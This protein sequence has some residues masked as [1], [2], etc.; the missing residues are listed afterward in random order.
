MVKVQSAK[1][2]SRRVPLCSLYREGTQSHRLE[3]Q[4]RWS[5]AATSSRT[6][7]TTWIRSTF[8]IWT[9]MEAR[10]T[11]SRKAR[12]SIPELS[13][14][15]VYLLLTRESDRNRSSLAMSLVLEIQRKAWRF[16]QSKHT[17]K[18]H[19]QSSHSLQAAEIPCQGSHLSE[20]RVL[21]DVGIFFLNI[22]ALKRT[23]QQKYLID[24]TD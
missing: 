1:V 21:I 9:R 3:T 20:L 4:P 12:S 10:W 6:P 19:K 22:V 8:W 16:K 23:I 17:T 11:S 18:H 7:W 2:L 14:Q 5:G 15:A 13:A 24:A